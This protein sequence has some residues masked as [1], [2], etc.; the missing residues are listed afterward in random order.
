M[1]ILMISP[2]SIDQLHFKGGVEAAIF[3][4]VEGLKSFSNIEIEV[5]SFNKDINEIV[6][7]SLSKY[8]KVKYFHINLSFQLS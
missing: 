3:N 8:V 7:Y 1:K 6:N 5:I 2:F 4:L